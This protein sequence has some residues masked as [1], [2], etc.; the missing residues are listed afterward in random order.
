M[1]AVFTTQLKK[2]KAASVDTHDLPL[3]GA[4]SNSAALPAKLQDH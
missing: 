1:R 3:S 2:S 4:R